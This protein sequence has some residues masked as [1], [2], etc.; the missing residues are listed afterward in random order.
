VQDEDGLTRP[1]AW[2][3]LRERG[4]EQRLEPVLRQHMRQRV[5]GN[6]TPRAFHFVTELPDRAVVNGKGAK[7][8]AGDFDEPE[9]SAPVWTA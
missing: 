3:V 9:A 4:G 2:V 1:E 5:G 6:K 7:A 8:T